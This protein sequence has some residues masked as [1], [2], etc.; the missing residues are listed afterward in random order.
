[1]TYTIMEIVSL[2]DDF[3]KFSNMYQKGAEKMLFFRLFKN[4]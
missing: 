3:F 1:M 4:V 2:I